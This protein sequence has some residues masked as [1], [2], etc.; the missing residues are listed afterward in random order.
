LRYYCDEIPS[1]NLWEKN[2]LVNRLRQLFR[3]LSDEKNIESSRVAGSYAR[4]LG[5]QQLTAMMM[6]LLLLTML[7][8][9]LMMVMMVVGERRGRR[10]GRRR[11]RM[12]MTHVIPAGRQ[13]Q[14][15]TGRG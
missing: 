13:I 2:F 6:L 9:L 14:V 12:L 15:E 11:L 5:E 3:T 10:A 8:T 7:M 1:T 4:P